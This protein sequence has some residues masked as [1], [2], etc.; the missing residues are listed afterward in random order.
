MNSKIL[1]ETYPEAASAILKHQTEVFRKSLDASDI[2]AEFRE[3]AQ[4]QELDYETVASF[5]DVNPRGVF[6]VFDNHGIY[7]NIVPYPDGTFTYQVLGDKA[8]VGT[9]NSFKTR[10]EAEKQVLEG[11]FQTLNDKLCQTAS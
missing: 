11:A 4:T 5:M 7:I 8:T 2:S 6:E 3:F 10:L 9:S 1:L